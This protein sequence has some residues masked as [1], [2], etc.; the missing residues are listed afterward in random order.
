[1]NLIKHDCSDIMI[2]CSDKMIIRRANPDQ[3]QTVRQFYHSLIDGIAGFSNSVGWI[4]DVYPA[5]GFL[6][7]SI[8]NGEQFIALESDSIIAAMVLNHKSNEG[9]REYHWPTDAMESEITVIHALGVHPSF[10]KKGCGK[11]MVQFAIETARQNRQKVIRLDV[12][13][14]NTAAEKLYTGMG[15]QYL[16]TL[17]LFYDDTGWKDFELFEYVL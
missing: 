9:Y 3:Y 8:S 4:K 1:M 15:F 16:H 2:N 12:L 11:A 13:K 10:F 6:M 5:P 7:E 14:G 17:P